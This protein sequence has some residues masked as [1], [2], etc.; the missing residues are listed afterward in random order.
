MKC[1]KIFRVIYPSGALV[2]AHC[3]FEKQKAKQTFGAKENS[4]IP[5][6]PKQLSRQIIMT[7]YS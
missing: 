6:P 2:I 4:F 7:M 5:F 3:V 1:T